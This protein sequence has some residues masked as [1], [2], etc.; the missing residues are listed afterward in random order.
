MYVLQSLTPPQN[1]Q[2]W[3]WCASVPMTGKKNSLLKPVDHL[4]A[5]LSSLCISK[6]VSQAPQTHPLTKPPYI[7]H[8]LSLLHSHAYASHNFFQFYLDPSLTRPNLVPIKPLPSYP[9]FFS[10]C[11]TISRSN[12]NFYPFKNPNQL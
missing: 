6:R 12:C 7:S 2:I 4:K 10:C 9:S 8:T 11:H 3:D 1:F 5:K